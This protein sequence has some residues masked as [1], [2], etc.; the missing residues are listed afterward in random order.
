M[1]IWKSTIIVVLFISSI[2]AFSQKE[3]N[4]WY[5]GSRAA[6]DFNSGTPVPLNNSDM[7]STEACSAISDTAGNLLFYT[8]G[9]TIW[10]TTHNPMSNGTGILG[11]NSS[12]QGTVI[13][14]APGACSEYYLFCSPNTWTN[15]SL[16]YSIIDMSL[17]GGLGAVTT[18]NVMLFGVSS[19]NISAVHH[20]NG[21]DIWVASLQKS[22]ADM[23]AYLVTPTGVS[24][25][26]I[27]PFVTFPI[28]RVWNG[29]L[30]FSPDGK[31]A[32]HGR[33]LDVTGPPA[34]VHKQLCQFNNT[35]GIAT[36]YVTLSETTLNANNNIV[37]CSF[38]HNSEKLYFCHAPVG[39]GN[40]VIDQYDVTA[41]TP[42]AV[43][44]S[45]TV[46]ATSVFPGN[47]ILDFLQLAPD[48]KIYV[49]GRQHWDSLSYI[50]NVDL[51]PASVGWFEEA[52]DLGLNEHRYS[53]PNFVESYFD[54][55][56]TYDFSAWAVS[57][58]AGPDQLNSCPGSLQL[59][60]DTG[61]VNYSWSPVDSVSNSTISNPTTINSDALVFYVSAETTDGC[62]VN[63]SVQV[64]FVASCTTCS[65]NLV[66]NPSFESVYGLP[67]AMGQHD[68]IYDWSNSGSLSVSASPDYYHIS[69]P[70]AFASLPNASLFTMLPRT[71]DVI[72]GIGLSSPLVPNFREY[73]DVQLTT[74]L[75][76]G[77][78]YELSFYMSNGEHNG[79]TSGMGCNNIGAHFSVGPLVQSGTSPLGITPSLNYNSVFYDSTWQLI[80][81]Q[82]TPA[83]A[84]DHLTIGNFYDDASTNFVTYDTVASALQQFAYVIFDDFC[85]TEIIIDSLIVSSDTIICMGDSI[86]LT[87]SG[88]S[89]GYSWADSSMFASVLVT[90][91]AY[92]ADPLATTTYAVYSATDTAYI[93]ITVET[94]PDVGING[95][96]GLCPSDAPVNLYDS[97]G[98]SP[99]TSG[100]W[101]PTLVGYEGLFDP[102]LSAGGTYQY[103]VT[104]TACPNDTS[105]VTVTIFSGA[106]AGGSNSITYCSTSSSDTLFN[107]VGGTPDATGAW[108]PTLA[109]GNLGVFDPASDP[110]GTYLYIVP[111]VGVCPPDTSSMVV[112]IDPATSSSQTF[113]ECDGYSIAVNGNVYTTTG[114][115]VDTLAGANANGCDSIVTT[116]LT[117]LPLATSTTTLAECTGFNVTVNGNVYSSTGIYI[118]TLVGASASGCDSIVTTD[119]TINSVPTI[120]LSST[121]SYCQGDSLLL[122]AG[123]TGADFLWSPGGDTLQTMYASAPGNYSVWV[124]DLN[125][126]SDSASITVSEVATPNVTLTGDTSICIGDSSELISING[127]VIW[128]T[129]D[130]SATISVSP[131]I[132][133]W[134]SAALSNSC[135]SSTD[136][137]YVA[138]NQ[139]PVA[140]A[141]N[142][143][144]VMP[145]DDFILNA[146]GGVSYSWSPT[147][148]LSCDNCPNPTASIEANTVYCVA[149]TDSNGCRS[150]DCVAIT[151]DASG[152]VWAPNIFS[153]NGDAL[154][155]VFYIRG[156]IQSDD[157]VL[158]IFNRWGEKVFET[159]DP[160]Q[161]WDGTQNGK[162]LNTAVFVYTA[163]GTTWGGT[164]FTLQGNITRFAK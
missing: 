1:K 50:T 62:P 155:D 131:I 161:G 139:L 5:F 57:F 61:F 90:D 92:M 106:N 138:I 104:G 72:M 22:T 115:F 151:I 113:S 26:V 97:L 66:S 91:S 83:M 158:M 47:E 69:A 129:G 112:T 123:N 51:A 114:V 88:S 143:T 28:N 73:I 37:G 145:L 15:D 154:N 17:N 132:S 10:D 80:T 120:P 163:S 41:G 133:G 18:K 157:F 8:N 29:S 64:S 127:A 59:E 85:L 65:G 99:D 3:V 25:P 12:H 68:S 164:E 32:A 78:T 84:D 7:I 146:S 87:A 110:S 39:G 136:S 98:G 63:D 141:G 156:S 54:N 35:T 81:F 44:A 160:A 24:A 147:T 38:S 100:I 11:H 89:T 2:S 56:G 71:G 130:T 48:G 107:L 118:D 153:P 96:V 119:L 20:A 9:E 95:A 34:V 42:A 149:V 33:I 162:Q 45:K 142:D 31:W 77:Q 16:C 117:I 109:G 58:D 46:V 23:Y 144:I 108:S 101:D 135:G 94:P 128:N 79:S 30:K 102:L 134:Y 6:L 122:D 52:L 60:A 75:T 116:D 67:T 14:K 27:S 74:P 49:S 76:P 43:D 137:I 150:N 40:K 36:P 121:G 93:T 124:S 82:Y 4:H 125:G 159:S 148:G 13:F 86:L 19:E 152:E 111:G 21:R 53:L 105:E 140:S 103:V 70:F 126:C 55:K